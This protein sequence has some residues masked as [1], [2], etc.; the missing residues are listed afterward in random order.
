MKLHVYFK[1]EINHTNNEYKLY[2]IIPNEDENN[3]DLNFKKKDPLIFHHADPRF[4][5]LGQRLLLKSSESIKSIFFK[6][7]IEFSH[8][9]FLLIK[10]SD[11]LNDTNE[12][13]NISNYK[14]YLYKMGVAE[15]IFTY[16]NSIPLEYN[17]VFLNG[18]MCGI[19][20]IYSNV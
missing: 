1:I 9:L 5:P 10:V 18:G 12:V 20:T 7:L 2:S 6:L 19:Y 17:I 4:K 14:K 16:G 11:L 13:E 3:I 8:V 15:D